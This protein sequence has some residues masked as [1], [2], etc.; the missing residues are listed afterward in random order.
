MAMHL[1]LNWVAFDLQWIYSKRQNLLCSKTWGSHSGSKCRPPVFNCRLS[2]SNQ[3]RT[4]TCFHPRQVNSNSLVSLQQ[5][6]K[7]L[8]QKARRQN[9]SNTAIKCTICAI[10]SAA[11][12]Y[13]ADLVAA[14][15]RNN[16]NRHLYDMHVIIKKL[17]EHEVEQRWNLKVDSHA[18][19]C[20]HKLWMYKVEFYSS[21]SL[22]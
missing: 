19:H 10:S 5:T 4:L 22:I 18:E 2:A 7:A 17:R 15:C 14:L 1:H 6:A 9:F 12:L 11:L 20:C 16:C 3:R 13:S 8:Q 21:N